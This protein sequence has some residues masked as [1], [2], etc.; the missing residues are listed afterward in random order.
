MSETLLIEGVVVLLIG[1]I[2]GYIIRQ[3]IVTAKKGTIEAEIEE[4]LLAAKREANAIEDEALMRASLLR[5][6]M[7]KS[8]ERLTKQ[9]ERIDKREQEVLLRERELT[10]ELSALREK[11][12]SLDEY[13]ETLEVAKKQVS[14]EL[15]IVAGLSTQ[16]AQTLLFQKI[17]E[18][19]EEDLTSRMLKLSRDGEERLMQKAQDILVNTIYRIANGP[20]AQF[21]T[22]TVEIE[23]EEIKGK[24]IGKEGRNIKTF[25]RLSGVELL[26]DE[27]PNGIVISC[28]DPVRRDRKSVV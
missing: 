22:A 16:E 14:K 1:G 24:V 6:E 8:E 2:S 7:Q 23:D 4:K 10:K 27:I 9:E 18:E 3:Y 17:K 11:T 26:I 15:E 13:K 28:F 20:I 21:M 19:G 12:R 5:E 25:E